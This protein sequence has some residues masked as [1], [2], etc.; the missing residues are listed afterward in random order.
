MYF[1]KY[2]NIQKVKKSNEMNKARGHF[3]KSKNIVKY[4]ELQLSGQQ[5]EL[6]QKLFLIAN[7]RQRFVK[8]V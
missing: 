4:Y 3:Y 7:K 5:M 1:S 6:A 2:Y 8:R